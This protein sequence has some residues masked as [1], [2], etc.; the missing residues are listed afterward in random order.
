M[1]HILLFLIRIP[2]EIN[3]LLARLALSTVYVQ[4]DFARV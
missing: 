2:F 1:D 4:M 3:V